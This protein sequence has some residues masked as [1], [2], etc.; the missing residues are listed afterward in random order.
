L[1]FVGIY[2]LFLK[3]HHLVEGLLKFAPELFSAMYGFVGGA[4]F[5]L[6]FLAIC[7][8]LL[9][10]RFYFTGYLLAFLHVRI[11][12]K[13]YGRLLL[14]LCAVLLSYYL[15]STLSYVSPMAKAE[16]AT[17]IADCDAL[18]NVQGEGVSGQWIRDTCVQGLAVKERRVEY[19]DLR[20]DIGDLSVKNQCYDAV[21]TE[22]RI[23]LIHTAVENKSI[24]TCN[25]IDLPKDSESKYY[26]YEQVAIAKVDDSICEKIPPSAGQ[27]I[28][29]P[30]YSIRTECYGLIS[31]ARAHD[32][33]T[34]SQ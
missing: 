22:K 31:A 1:T 26:C 7:I 3:D 6:L 16:M 14:L 23:N 9:I 19:C 29:A 11:F 25:Q 27:T 21:T 5:G 15:Y 32:L 13:R 10:A 4:L 24:D 18:I 17:S 34:Q 30:N 2:G 12:K 20:S 8:P 28:A 33:Q